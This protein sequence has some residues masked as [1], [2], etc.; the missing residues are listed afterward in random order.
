MAHAAAYELD[1]EKPAGGTA[2]DGGITI[3]TTTITGGATTQ[4]LF[5]AAG[6]VSSSADFTY[7]STNKRITGA[8]GG[9]AVQLEDTNGASIGY[10]AGGVGVS[11]ALS[12]GLLFTGGM[13]TGLAAPAAVTARWTDAKLETTTGI[14]LAVGSAA[15]AT[16]ATV[17]FLQLPTCAGTP[18]GAAPDRSV[19]LDS[20]NGVVY[21][22]IAGAWEAIALV[23]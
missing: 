15:I 3:G 23:P 12:T 2:G 7:S 14:N 21:V 6:V 4:V 11:C 18:T 1:S 8:G 17:G 13:A 16:N 22:R 20:T 10:L 19:V 9:A 5:N